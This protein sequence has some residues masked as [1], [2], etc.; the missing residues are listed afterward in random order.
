MDLE[1]TFKGLIL[2]RV[3]VVVGATFIY[4]LY[5][6][7]DE[8]YIEQGLS[9]VVY[10]GSVVSLVGMASLIL[11]YKFIPWGRIIFTIS[12][13]LWVL[14]VFLSPEYYVPKGRIYDALNWINGAVTGGIFAM[15][16]LTEIKERFVRKI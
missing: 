16:Y 3:V 11:L 1:K 7:Y 14:S 13:V 9:P 6:P 4:A 5:T 8:K 12:I 2:L 10:I 15:L